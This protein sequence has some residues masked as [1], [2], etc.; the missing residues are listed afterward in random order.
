MTFVDITERRSREDVL[1]LHAQILDHLGEGVSVLDARG[2]YQLVN[3]AYERMF[4]FRPGELLGQDPRVVR[5]LPAKEAW[6]SIREL[7]SETAKRGQWAGVLPCRR[8][9]GS[10]ILSEASITPFRRAGQTYF[11]GVHSDITERSRLAR[12]LAE[13]EELY[14][15]LFEAAPL[16]LGISDARGNLLA[17]NDAMLRY[18]GYERKDIEKIR[19][20]QALYYDP[21]DRKKILKEVRARGRVDRYEVRYRNKAGA[22][23]WTLTSLRPV[24]YRGQFCMQAMVEDITERKAAE[25]ELQ[26]ESRSLKLVNTVALAANQARAPQD[27]LRTVLREVC[28]FAGWQAGHAYEVLGGAKREL[29]ALDLWY[30]AQGQGFAELRKAAA[31]L[32]LREGEGLPGRVLKRGAALSST[33]LAREPLLRRISRAR[34]PEAR[35]ACAFPVWAGRET[36]AVLEFFST[37]TRAPDARLTELFTTVMAQAGRVFERSRAEEQLRREKEFSAH[38]I[39]A[40][41]DGVVAV[42]RELRYTLWNSGMERISGVPARATLGRKA[43]ELFPFLKRTGEIES[44]RQTLKGQEISTTDRP[45][46]V[47]Q[48]GRKGFYEARYTALRDESGKI[49]GGLGVIREITERKR[50]EDSLRDLSARLLET[51]EAE[52]RRVARELHDGVNQILSAAQMQVGALNHAGSGEG[53]AKLRTLLDQAIGELRRI[54]HNLRPAVLDDLGL[55]AA[56]RSACDEFREQSGIGLNLR[57]EGLPARLPAQVELTVF[58]ILQEALSNAW[59]HAEARRVEV[60]LSANRRLLRLAV[61][62]DGKGWHPGPGD[63]AARHSR[64]LGLDNMR[65]RAQFAGGRFEIRTAP[66]R[67]TEI[68][69]RIPLA[70]P[71]EDSN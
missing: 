17:Y 15:T 54:S 68:R 1:R 26:R 43:V 19:N 51:Q 5:D 33:R 46:H 40:S 11:V 28:S 50:A 69:V 23:Y 4:G 16:G 59:R 32:R 25:E 30:A 61:R 24:R 53:A 41:F 10:R 18:G 52:R 9:D 55:P 35:M 66:G 42:D 65:E 2:R 64:G 63:G 47:A 21:A 14:R 70:P 67:G 44:I 57:L 48:T 7:M 22:P 45:Y 39:Q 12:E 8:K 58:R 3:R 36:V 62:D 56:V 34:R 20:V 13:R 6:R 27:V 31:G 49:V 38:V 29:A 37:G 71:Q 60:R